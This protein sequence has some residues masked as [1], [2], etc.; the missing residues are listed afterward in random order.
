MTALVKG[1]KI[2]SIAIQ[3]QLAFNIFANRLSNICKTKV[4]CKKIDTRAP[5]TL[6]VSTYSGIIY[7]VYRISN[8]HTPGAQQIEN[9]LGRANIAFWEQQTKFPSI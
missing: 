1:S 9:I 7:S 6:I 4:P 8:W 3:L 2:Y 5:S